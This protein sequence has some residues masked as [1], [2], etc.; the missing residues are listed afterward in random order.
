M[1]RTAISNLQ[2]LDRMPAHRPQEAEKRVS[3]VN[4]AKP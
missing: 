3:T 4:R 2:Q 1:V